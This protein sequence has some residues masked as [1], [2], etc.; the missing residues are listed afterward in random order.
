MEERFKF[1]HLM[2]KTNI[3]WQ[4]ILFFILKNYCYYYCHSSFHEAMHLSVHLL[5]YASSIILKVNQ[6]TKLLI[7]TCLFKEGCIC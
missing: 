3:D 6:F 5:G 2:K 1:E 7:S 4:L